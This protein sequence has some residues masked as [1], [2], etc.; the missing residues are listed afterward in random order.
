MI[1]DGDGSI[2]AGGPKTSPRREL[3]PPLSPI[4]APAENEVVVDAAAFF[5]EDVVKIH[6][7]GGVGYSCRWK[8]EKATL[9]EISGG[10]RASAPL[11]SERRASAPMNLIFPLGKDAVAGVALET[12]AEADHGNEQG[13]AKDEG[14]AA[15]PAAPAAPAQPHRTL[16]KL[17]RSPRKG[18]QLPKKTD[19]VVKTTAARINADVFALWEPAGQANLPNSLWRPAGANVPKTPPPRSARVALRHTLDGRAPSASHCIRSRAESESQES[20]S[21]LS[22]SATPCSRETP[23]SDAQSAKP[24]AHLEGEWVSRLDGEVRG[25]VLNGLFHW[26]EDGTTSALSVHRGRGDVVSMS[27][28]GVGYAGVL[29]ED[30]RILRWADGDVWARVLP[31]GPLEIS[32]KNHGI[33]KLELEECLEWSQWSRSMSLNVNR[34]AAYSY[35]L[36]GP[37][38]YDL[39]GD[40]GGGFTDSFDGYS[41]RGPSVMCS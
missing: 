25:R 28:D 2:A 12:V 34:S 39:G 17:K 14:D 9:P 32:L 41:P 37:D 38:S 7:T 11:L 33:E 10:R 36:G 3:L 29:S 35:G 40:I 4:E 13:K 23:S 5:A 27:V 21:S 24:A 22:S 6:T 15:A 19:Q 16:A 8:G 18:L 26:E 30:G 31:Y 20:Q 1:S